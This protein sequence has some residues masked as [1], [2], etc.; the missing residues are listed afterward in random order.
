MIVG[1]LNSVEAPYRVLVTGLNT[2]DEDA[3]DEL[4]QAFAARASR[5][6]PAH[7][8]GTGAWLEVS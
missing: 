6:N 3:F 8:T 5:D 2:S 7:I 1:D 4:V